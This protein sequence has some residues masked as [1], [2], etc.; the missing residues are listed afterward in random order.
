MQ[1]APAVEPAPEVVPERFLRWLD[2]AS[3]LIS[4]VEKALFLSLTKDYQ[5]DAFIQQF[6]KSGG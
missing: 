3:V 6:W 1:C 5:R 4:R 2:E